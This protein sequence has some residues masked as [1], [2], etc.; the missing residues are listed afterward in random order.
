MLPDTDA[1]VIQALTGYGVEFSN[2]KSPNTLPATR[3]NLLAGVL[4][5]HAH[6]D[7]LAAA[8]PVASDSQQLIL[9]KAFRL[10][11]DKDAASPAWLD[12]VSH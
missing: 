2:A 6:K 5:L 1:E 3:L 12:K 8:W 4:W 10:D 9:A 11:F 7:D